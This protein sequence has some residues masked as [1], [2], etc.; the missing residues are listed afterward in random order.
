MT[1]NGSTIMAVYLSSSL[2]SWLGDLFKNEL[3]K[4]ILPQIQVIVQQ[5]DRP[6]LHDDNYIVC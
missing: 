5:L 6:D 4:E 1:S 3:C 2:E